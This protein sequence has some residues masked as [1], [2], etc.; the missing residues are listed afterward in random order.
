[1]ADENLEPAEVEDVDLQKSTLNKLYQC[2][3]AR[4]I[5][6]KRKERIHEEVRFDDLIAD[7]TGHTGEF[8]S[9][10]FHGS[11]S[12]PSFKIYRG[13]NDG[14]CFGCP[15]GK[16]YYDHIRFVKEI[17][18]VSWVEALRWIEKKYDLPP[19]PDVDYED[20]EDEATIQITYTDLCEPY[21]QKASRD[22]LLSKDSELADEYIRI[23]FESADLIR[24]AEEARK[25]GEVEE[26]DKLEIRATT[27]LAKV[28]G[29]K[30]LES[31]MSSKE[32]WDE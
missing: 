5:N 6:P 7:L 3:A 9:C 20:E 14:F 17:R 16:G 30:M 21:L 29:H 32:V 22:V 31:I 11:D 23:Y 4:G 25:Q 26:A 24:M 28:L 2:G 1:V 27:R 12:S 10:P 15:P 18:G 13:S 8:I 19:L